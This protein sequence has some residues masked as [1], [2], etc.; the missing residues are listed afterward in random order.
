MPDAQHTYSNGLVRPCCM[1]ENLVVTQRGDG[2]HQGLRGDLVVR[3]CR[4]C[5]ARHIE[6]S[7][8]PGRAFAR[9]EGL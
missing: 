4:T 7:V 5:K 2:E 8:A 6:L 9:G 1:P 3:V